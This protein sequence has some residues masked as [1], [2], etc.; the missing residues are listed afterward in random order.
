MAGI[1]PINTQPETFRF[2]AWRDDVFFAADS[3]VRYASYMDPLDSDSDNLITKFY[4][5][6]FDVSPGSGNPTTAIAYWQPIVSG[7]I[8]TITVMKK[9]ADI[10]SDLI[11]LRHDMVASDS[12]YGGAAAAPTWD[13][14]S[15]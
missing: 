11:V 6:Q 8:D 15:F 7:S 5:A 14:G 13:Y 3:V 10:D 2:P 1:K 9:M 12:D 4:V